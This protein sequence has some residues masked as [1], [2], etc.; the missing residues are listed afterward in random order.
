MKYDFTSIMDR[1]GRDAI[2]VDMVGQGGGFA[3]GGPKEGF[4]VI[5][6]WVADMNFPAV[7]TV[8]EAMI[9]R[10]MHPAYGY[11][12]PTAEYF[13][14]IIRWQEIRNDVRG[15]EARHIGYENGV[16]GGVVTALNTFCSRGDKV[17]VH[18]PTYIGFTNSLHNAGYEI[19][20]S[21]L[22]KDGD[23]LWRMDFADMERQ[24]RDHKIH[25]AILCSPHNPTGRVWER[26]ELEQ[27]ME[28]YK[29][30]D[31]YVVSDEIWSDLILTGFRHT[32][33]QS[34][35]E[36]ARMRTVALYAP[37]KTFNLAG[38]VGSYHIIYNPRLKDRH[39]KEAS[40]SHYNSMNVMSMHALIGAYRPEGY[41]WVDELRQVITGNI[42]W[43][44]EKIARFDG[45][46]VTKPQGT[47]MLFLDCEGW[48]RKHGC[49]VGVLL[50][51][52]WDVGVCWQDGRPFHGPYHI[53]MNLALPLSRVQEAFGRLETYVFND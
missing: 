40:L 4:D 2:A 6:M 29:K 35:S 16:L 13:D 38:L 23:G 25:A 47:Y 20:H 7:P 34:V 53:R 11:F 30:Y 18:S 12:S 45:I 14:A 51:K 43:A 8:A 24:L 17:L 48:C 39:D 46:S 26:R 28:L 37:S 21:P 31:V 44:V 42:D 50:K 36:D 5:P 27:A 52:G 1:R 41:E 9:E 22:V 19:V 33:T 49:D 15:L 3:P 10:A 32:P